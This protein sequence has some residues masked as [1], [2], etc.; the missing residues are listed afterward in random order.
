MHG[1]MARSPN[2]AA[3]RLGSCNGQAYPAILSLKTPDVEDIA[4]IIW[5]RQRD[6]LDPGATAYNAE[7]RDLSIPSRFWDEF[8]LDAHAVLSFL[9]EK[10]IIYEEDTN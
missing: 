7:W 8:L 3:F 1:Q 2:H 6:A 4:R 9:Y 10:H 5:K